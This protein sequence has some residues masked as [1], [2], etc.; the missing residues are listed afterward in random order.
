MLWF[1]GLLGFYVDFNVNNVFFW[2]TVTFGLHMDLTIP[3][4]II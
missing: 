4:D 1:R 2:C 3:V